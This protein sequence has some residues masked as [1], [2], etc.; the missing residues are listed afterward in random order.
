MKVVNNIFTYLDSILVALILNI[1]V[2]RYFMNIVDTN[3][4]LYLLYFVCIVVLFYKNKNIVTYQYKKNTIIKYYTWYL[5]GIICYSL[6]TSVLFTGELVI[7]YKFLISI[8]IAIFCIGF[9][10]LHQK[11][12]LI[13]FYI[14]NISYGLLVLSSPQRVNSYLAGDVNYLNMTLTLGLCLTISLVGF[15]T[16]YYL[17]KKL[18]CLFYL[19]GGIFFFI[20]T[21]FFPARGVL[22]FPPLIAIYTA[23]VGRKN[24]MGKFVIFIV[25]LIVLILGAYQYFI[26]TAS[27]YALIHMTGLFENTEGES[28][29]V[30]WK[31]SW[32]E[33]IDNLWIF[34]GGGLNKFQQEIGFYPHN[35]YLHILADFG[36]LALVGFIYLTIKVFRCYKEET[37]VFKINTM[38]HGFIYRLSF[39]SFFYYLLTFCKS[40][41]MYDSCPLLIMM[42]F[43]LTFKCFNHGSTVISREMK[44]SSI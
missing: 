35:I 6:V 41:S 13:Y 38:S 36:I 39:S 37:S 26:S 21:M 34:F 31:Q 23:Y 16:F 33:I 43:C 30:V 1:N 7:F 4:I 25:F 19:I 44:T 11:K 27:E 22:L 12:V 20:V 42:S 18:V 10:S 29:I 8:L 9:D 17:N 2:L 24:N 15:V 28:R 32:N 3:A 14:I 40:F 5:C